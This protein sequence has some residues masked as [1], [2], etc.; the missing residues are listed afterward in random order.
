MGADESVPPV[1]PAGGAGAGGL[2]VPAAARR[3]DAG[4]A[5]DDREPSAPGRRS[6][7][8]PVGVGGQ[9]VR[10]SDRVRHPGVA[11]QCH[12]ARVT[13]AQDMHSHRRRFGGGV[14]GGEGAGVSAGVVGA[15]ASTS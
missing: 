7:V 12:H 6:S 1:L 4:G 5:H 2:A 14:V 11:G 8:R 13:T 15:W 10:G 3:A 9:A